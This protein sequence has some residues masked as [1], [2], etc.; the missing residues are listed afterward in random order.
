MAYIQNNERTYAPHEIGKYGQELSQPT[1]MKWKSYSC[2]RIDV[3]YCFFKDNCSKK[4]K[5]IKRSIVYLYFDEQR[6]QIKREMTKL[7][8]PNEWLDE[9][10]ASVYTF[11]PIQLKMY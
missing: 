1:E 4:K 6:K 7:I 2:D 3:K 11:F 9:I 5:I 10:I 8:K